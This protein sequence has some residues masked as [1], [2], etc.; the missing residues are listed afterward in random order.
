LRDTATKTLTV[1]SFRQP[2]KLI[3]AESGKSRPQLDRLLKQFVIDESFSTF[4]SEFDKAL[5]ATEQGD[6]GAYIEVVT[7]KYV[8]S[9][10]SMKLH[11]SVKTLS[12]PAQFAGSARGSSERVVGK[13]EVIR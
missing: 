10:L 8:A 5:K 1:L 4:P 11:E 6:T 13:P 9:P 3:P 7:D 2:G 12:E